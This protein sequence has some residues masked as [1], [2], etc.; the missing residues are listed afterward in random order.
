MTQSTANT[1]RAP[2]GVSDLQLQIGLVLRRA[3]GAKL[4]LEQIASQ[5]GLKVGL[6]GDEY[7]SLC[8]MCDALS[9][10]K[11]RDRIGHAYP[12]KEFRDGAY[13]IEPPREA[14]P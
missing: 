3:N 9:R 5:L 1:Q 6:S 8:H 12:S 2:G 11:S 14:A 4:S 13:W 10:L 7:Q